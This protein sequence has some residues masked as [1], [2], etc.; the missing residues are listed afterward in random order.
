[1]WPSEPHHANSQVAVTASII[2]MVA[3]LLCWTWRSHSGPLTAM[4]MKTN[5]L[6]PTFNL[7]GLPRCSFLIPGP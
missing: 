7:G 1:V 5:I 2:T 3:A 6:F 4:G